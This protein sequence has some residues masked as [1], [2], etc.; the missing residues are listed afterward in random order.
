MYTHRMC[1]ECGYIMIIDD[2]FICREYF[3]VSSV[4]VF[5]NLSHRIVRKIPTMQD[6]EKAVI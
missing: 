5:V 1:A 2:S 4:D 6:F 3:F